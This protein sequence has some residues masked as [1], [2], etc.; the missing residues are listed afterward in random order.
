MFV[1]LCQELDSYG[2]VARHAR[3]FQCA[4]R[5]F[6]WGNRVMPSNPMTWTNEIDVIETDGKFPDTAV[7]TLHKNTSGD[8]GVPD[9]IN[10]PN[11]FL[12]NQKLLGGWHTYGVLWTTNQV[13]W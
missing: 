12:L 11:N 8:G 10:Q 9:Q 6:V 5:P 4:D 7:C 2:A 3:F 1:R 13:T